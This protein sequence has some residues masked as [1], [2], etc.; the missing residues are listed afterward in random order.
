MRCWNEKSW[1]SLRIPVILPRI[2][3][4]LLG[5]G[6]LVNFYTQ[7]QIENFLHS[8]PYRCPLRWITGLKCAFCGM[9]H[10][11]IS[12]YRGDF[13]NAVH[14]NILS[15]PLFVATIFLLA[16]YSLNRKPKA[17]LRAWLGSSIAVMLVYAI[18]RNIF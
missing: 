8:V 17:N 18:I 10:A 3:L 1:R 6:L 5:C 12:I 9:T 16:T 4:L 2:L 15:I 13:A 7:D 14:E 11:W